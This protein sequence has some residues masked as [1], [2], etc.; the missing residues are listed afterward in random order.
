MK[1]LCLL[2]TLFIGSFTAAQTI[3]RFYDYNRK[4]CEPSHAIYYST[5]DKTDSGWQV[6][7]YFLSTKKLEMI[8]VYTDS[9]EKI[10]NGSFAW[11][12]GNG[13]L[14]STGVYR[15]NEK[16]GIWISLHPNSYMSD[17]AFYED[18]R[19]IGTRLKWNSNG[20]LSDS[21]SFDQTG[22]SIAVSWF[23]NG[24]IAS[25]G[26]INERGEPF[27]KWQYFYK[28]GGISSSEI[29]QA[30]KL[31]EYTYYKP[32]GSISNDTSITYTPP[33]FPGGASAWGNYLANRFRPLAEASKLNTPEKITILI[34]FEVD[35][36]GNVINP[37]VRVPIQPEF[38]KI[39]L[40]AIIKSPKWKPAKA[41]NRFI[42]ASTTQ[43]ITFGAT[44]SN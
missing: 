33:S 1:N 42:K 13:I 23:S 20:Y 12:Y 9:T 11:Y 30:G 32:D 40:E 15:N 24:N 14:K 39:A 27:G 38:D 17:S 2:V 41:H 43:S 28:Q 18:G 25:A 19:I 10:M 22:R 3:E 16:Q 21:I 35:E 8:G 5:L 29:Y 37:M 36:E 44:P 31:L 7:T 4:Q 34:D 26:R 6:K